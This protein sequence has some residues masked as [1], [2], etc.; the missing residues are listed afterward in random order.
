LKRSVGIF[1]LAILLFVSAIIASVYADDSKPLIG[2]QPATSPTA[3]QQAQIDRKYGMFCHFGINTY[4]NQEW[5]DGKLPPETY[6]PPADLADKI[7]GWVKTAHDAGMRY[8]LCITKHH[9]GF[10]MWDTACTDYCV[11]NPKVK[12]HTDVVKAVSAACHKYGIKFAVYYSLWDRHVPSSKDPEQYKQYMLRQLTELMTNYGPVCELW[13]DGSWASAPKNWHLDEVY[14]TVKRLQPDCQITSN[15]TIA[16]DRGKQ[17]TPDKLKQ[18]MEIKYFPSD[19]R[20]SDPYLPGP[21]DPKL[22]SHAGKLY[23][24]PYEATVTLS[25]NGSWF[26]HP[27]T[28]AKSVDELQDIFESA[29]TQDDCLVFNLPPDRNGLLVAD[30]R[31]ALLGLADRLKLTPDGPFPK[32]LV[33]LA[34]G[35]TAT[36]SAVWNDPKDHTSYEPSN[37]VDGNPGSRWACGPAGTKTAWLVVDLGKPVQFDAL[38]INEYGSRIRKYQIEIL[39]GADGWQPIQTGTTIGARCEIP[40]PQTTASKFR[41]N[42]LDSTD[43]PSI[44][45]ILVFSKR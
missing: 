1:Q 39:T 3:A 19:F 30:Q 12:N 44:Y 35:A 22:F 40:L 9:D 36:A 14:D 4:A 45:E 5:T 26:Y 33:N 34:A 11:A 10:C 41:V 20:I 25:S 23:Y 27:G 43:A 38:R 6:D 8:F 28:G 42:I 31:Q 13:L 15:W 16:D 17:V 2:P 29:T 18:G 37:A 7:D 21:L 32:P 24:M